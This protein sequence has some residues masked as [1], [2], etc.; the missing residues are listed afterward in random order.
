MLAVGHLNGVLSTCL[1]GSSFVP[2]QYSYYCKTITKHMLVKSVSY[3]TERSSC[4]TV[5]PA[6]LLNVTV[7]SVNKHKPGCRSSEHSF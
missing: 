1:W 6:G 3:E 7:V 5:F 4:F 2:E